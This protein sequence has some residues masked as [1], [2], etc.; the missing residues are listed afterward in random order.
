MKR[1]FSRLYATKN[2]L[3]AKKV[4]LKTLKFLLFFSFF[5]KGEFQN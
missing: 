4:A 2:V 3:K 5:G 1:Y